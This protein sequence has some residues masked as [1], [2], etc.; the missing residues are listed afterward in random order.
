MPSGRFPG[1]CPI[2]VPP[3]SVREIWVILQMLPTEWKVF[4]EEFHA[5][6]AEKAAAEAA[7]GKG[8]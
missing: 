8:R 7:P 3:L 2:G 5:Q 6:F 1:P 4:K